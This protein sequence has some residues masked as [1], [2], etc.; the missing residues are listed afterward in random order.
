MTLFS[1]RGLALLVLRPAALG[2]FCGRFPPL[3][4]R[5]GF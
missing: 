2:G 5:H 4:W 3:F 1:F